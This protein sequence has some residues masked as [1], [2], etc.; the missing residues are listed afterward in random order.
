M[1][2]FLSVLGVLLLGSLILTGCGY[3]TAYKGSKIYKTEI[4]K[5]MGDSLH[6]WILVGKTDAHDGSKIIVTPT[7]IL[8]IQSMV[9]WI[10]SLN[11]VV[12]GQ[13]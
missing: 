5:V 3:A 12:L 10:L 6:N 2:K 8:I 7:Q 9:L 4:T 11:Q 1:K 13:L